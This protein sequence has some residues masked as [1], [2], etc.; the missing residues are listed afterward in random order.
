MIDYSKELNDEQRDAI[1]YDGNVYLVA[2]PGSGK[3]RTLVYKLAKE[4]E[5]INSTKRKIAA[6]TYT[7]VA[8]DEI[9][10]RIVDLGV[11]TSAL[12]IGTIHSFCLDW[13]LRPF[14]QY[15]S[16]LE[17]GFTLVD[18]HT[19]E[20]IISALSGQYSNPKINYFDCG[21]FI[22]KKGV[23]VSCARNKSAN[24]HSVISR[25]HEILLKNKQID[26][27]Q[28]LHYSYVLIMKHLEVSK[29]LS[30]IFSHIL[31]DEF[32]D[33]KELQY[34]I[35][36]SI[37]RAGKGR[38]N[39]F[40]VGDPNQSIFGSLGGYAINLKELITL[41]NQSVKA[42]ELDKNYRSSSRIV[43]YCKNFRVYDSKMVS[44]SKYKDH[45]GLISYSTNIHKDQLVDKISS[46]VRYHIEV[47]KIPPNE[48]CVIAPW[49]IHLASLTRGL[50]N[51]LPGYSFDGPGLTPIYRDRENFW[52][53][54][55]RLLLTTPS[56]NIYFK[57]IFWARDLL[58]TMSELELCNDSLRDKDL[59]RI[60]NSI[61]VNEQ[62]GLRYLSSAFDDFA[63]KV[64]FSIDEEP[65]LKE[66]FVAFLTSS[67]RRIDR[68][69]NE[70]IDYAG[71]IEDFR[72][73]FIPKTGVKISSIH[74][75]KG[76]E[77]ETVISFGLLEGMVP[78]FSDTDKIN[79]AN[80][81]LY[82]IASRAKRHL[83]L[84]AESGRRNAPTPTLHTLSYSKY[85]QL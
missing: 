50:A 59:L 39:L 31:L 74:G 16:E 81:L 61:H 68:I 49:W 41:T 45:A 28:I 77:Y 62:D 14:S 72:R 35:I 80:K 30:G 53:R 84:I 70:G 29:S 71:S 79:T 55:S 21:Y 65:S 4:L 36:S 7:N 54:L 12:W 75:V 23:Q 67:N 34:Q 15:I 73:A 51:N 3:T 40:M 57:R 1:V 11:D 58:H 10:E 6:I 32:Q 27:E 82:V 2:C 63:S 48:I 8:A 5:E 85:D 37:I 60:I 56:P 26:F 24:V 44:N 13:I 33:T 20:E 47:L 78:H 42:F 46:L 25:Y 9:K 52:Y 83:H 17:H 38:C 64:G 66:Q 19:S 69:R 18:N 43:D 76:E 22:N